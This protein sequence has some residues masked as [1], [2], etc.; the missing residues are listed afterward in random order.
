[1]TD[2]A[3]NYV[4]IVGPQGAGKGT[5]AAAVAPQL[6]LEHIA[7]GDLFRAILSSDSE[8]G[9]EVRRYYDQG[10]LVPDDLTVR[11]L[12]AHIEKLLQERPDVKGVLLDGFPR[13]AA[14]AE[15][16]DSALTERGEAISAV[17]L[18]DVP[19]DELM[20]RLTGRL[21]CSNCGATYHRE[22]N[23]PKQSK[24][25][26]ECGSELYQRSDDTPDAVARR[27]GI[28]Y[29]QT[30]PILDHYREQGVLL[31]IDGNQE[32]Q[33]VTDDILS[34]LRSRVSS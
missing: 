12:F 21:V 19:R 34:G 18:V 8:L 11:V 4:I 27:L 30:E 14:Q 26:D 6:G 32:I 16:L 24:V 31:K 28:Y 23:P 22:F 2:N 9:D 13:N 3:V 1:M 25:C 33:Q 20:A 29:E 5:Q 15:A 17:V 10:E 7:T